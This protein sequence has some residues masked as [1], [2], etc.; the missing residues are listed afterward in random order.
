M[1]KSEAAAAQHPSPL[2]LPC[3]LP[4]ADS[5][6]PA[7]L[8]A[9]RQ[10]PIHDSTFVK[11]R[12]RFRESDD[13]RS[14][15]TLL[16]LYADHL[17]K[18]D[19]DPSRNAGKV[20][21][22]SHQAHELWLDRV[23]D[24]AEAA[25]ALARAVQA[26]PE[27]ERAVRHLYE[28]YSELGWHTERILLLRWRIR[29][30]ERTT[31]AAIP[32]L[33]VELAQI[34]DEH[35]MA[36]KEA[37][38]IYERALHSDPK[39]R[40]ASEGLIRLYLHASSWDRAAELMT[41]ELTRLD[42]G[43][44]RDRV[45]ELHLRLARI[46]HE[47]HDNIAGAAVHLQSA[48]KAMPDNVRALRAFGV[49]YLGSGKA[50]DEGMA[51]AAD[52]FFRAAK[53]AHAQNDE[54]EALKLLRRTLNLRPDHY[55]AG[56][57]LAEIFSDH[58]RWTDL[59][60]L[61]AQW[62]DYVAPEDAY[63]LWIQRGELLEEH[64]VRREDARLCYETAAQ[65]EA[66]GG[67]A[68]QYLERLYASLGD[69]E[70]LAGLFEVHVEREPASMPT[71]KLLRAAEIYREELHNDQRASFFFYMVLERE[72]FNAVAFEGYKEH[73]RRKNKWAHLRDLIFYQIEEA[74]NYS[75]PDNPLQSPSFA[76]EF[77]EVAE[78]CEKRL[79]DPDGALDAWQRLQS[80]YP[81]DRRPR[82]Q[83]ARLSKRIR[84]LDQI[85]R[86]QGLEL[87]RSSDQQTRLGLLRR[88]AAVYRERVVDPARAIDHLHESLTI[89]PEDSP[90]EEML[91]DLYS[92][93]GDSE[94]L[95]AILRQHYEAARRPAKQMLL[96]RRM[97]AIWHDDLQDHDNAI[98]ACEQL[99]SY[100][101]DDAEIIHRLQNLFY[102]TGRQEE[103]YTSLEREL[104]ITTEPRARSR[105]LL[106]MGNIAE[107]QLGD[108]RRASRVYN[109]LLALDPHNLEIIDK[110][111]GMY[112][113]D[114]RFDDL[115][116]LLGKA[117]ASSK[118]PPIRQLDY[119]TRLGHLA[120]GSL[121]DP[122]L[123]CSAFEKVLRIHHD[124][125]DAVEALTRLYRTI[126]AWHGLAAMLGNLQDLVDSDEEVL[127]LGLERAEVLTDNLD[128]A[129][130]AARVLE[131][132]DATI[133]PGHPE[134]RA[135]LTATYK[136]AGDHR[137]AIRHA[138]IL[139]LATPERAERQSLFE[140][141]ASSWIALNETKSGLAAFARFVE[142]VGYDPS[143]LRLQADLQEQAGDFAGALQTHDRLLREEPDPRRNVATLE[144]M[145]E[146]AEDKQGHH[147]R[148][149]AL[150]G[151]ALGIN[152]TDSRIR[153]K[154]EALAARHSMWKD[155]LAAYSERYNEMSHRADSRGQIEL[156]MNASRTAEEH[157]GDFD[158][159]FAWAKKA[160]L[161]ALEAGHEAQISRPPRDR[162]RELAQT[163][164]LWRQQL[165]VY[166]Q[167]LAL[168]RQD[169]SFGDFDSFELLLSAADVARERLHEPAR[170]IGFLTRAHRIRPEDGELGKQIEEI[171]ERHEL[172][173]ELGEHYEGLLTR[174]ESALSHFDAHVALARLLERKL[175]DAKGAATRLRTA[176]EQIYSDDRSLAEEALDLA[177]SLCERHE[178]WE[179]LAD[180]RQAAA[181]R[182]FDRRAIPEGLRSLCQAAT[183]LDERCGD[184]LAALRTLRGGLRYDLTGAG[185]L[186]PLRALAQRSDDARADGE[187]P[188][189]TLTILG[190]L[191][192]LIA[193]TDDPTAQIR[194][195]KE[196]A[197]IRERTLDDRRGALAEWLRILGLNPASEEARFE[198]DRLAE[199]G[200]LWD[201]M[202]LVPAWD[203]QQ[204]RRDRSPATPLT[205]RQQTQENTHWE[206]IAELY[207]DYLNRPEY[208]LRAKL[209]TWRLRRE[210][211]PTE[212]D[213]GPL[214]GSIWHHARTIG[215]YT[216]PPVH[217]DTL[218]WPQVRAPEIDDDALW[219]KLGLHP[220]TLRPR[221]GRAQAQTSTPTTT[222][223]DLSEIE[224]LDEPPEVTGILDFTELEPLDDDAIPEVTGILDLTEIEALDEPPP[225]ITGVVELSEI[226]PFDDDDDDD[227]TA[228][229]DLA[230]DDPGLLKFRAATA[231][232]PDAPITLDI[233]PDD[234]DLLAFR[235]G[236]LGSDAIAAKKSTRPP[237]P[238]GGPPRPPSR[239]HAAPPRPPS[240]PH[241]APLRA[242]PPRPPSRPIAAMTPAPPPSLPALTAGLPV[243]PSL[244]A[245]ILQAR[246]K[247]SGPWQEIEAAYREVT[248]PSKEDRARLALALARLY[249]EGA[250]LPEQSFALLEE[251]L[252]LL[253]EHTKA[254]AALDALALRR[255]DNERL[256]AA[257]SLL[258]SEVTLPEH[259]VEYSLRLA[260][261]QR[262]AGHDDAAETAYRGVLGV[263]P[264]HLGAL[265]ALAS[266]YDASGRD[267]EY[268]E[269]RG[270]LVDL[271]LPEAPT[272]EREALLRG[273]ARD[274]DQRL[275]RID[276]AIKRLEPLARELPARID[277]QEELADL[278]L[279]EEEWAA[280]ATVLR[281]ALAHTEGGC[282]EHLRLLSR[283]AL[284]EENKLD[285][286][287]AAI[288]RWQ[289]I[290]GTRAEDNEALAHLQGLYL[291][292]EHWQELIEII[293]R[294]LA[295]AGSARD[296]RIAI[297]VIKARA[298][299]EGF[300]DEAAA[301]S[302][303]EALAVEDPEND[304]VILGLSRLYRRS[305]RTDEGIAL[306]RRR[307]GEL[308]ADAHEE[309]ATLALA[310]ASIQSDEVGDLMEATAT[311]EEALGENPSHRELLRR[312]AS[313][314][315]QS[316]DLPVLVD[317]LERLGDA[318]DLLEAAP[319]ARNAL[320]D[321]EWSARLY[322]KVLASE[323]GA[324]DPK[325][326][327]RIA[328]ALS[329]LTE[330]RIAAGDRAGVD[331]LLAERIAALPTPLH[332][333]VLTE[334]GRTLWHSTADIDL[335][336]ARFSA[337]LAA[338]PDCALASHSLG[339]VLFLAGRYDEAEPILEEAVE[340][341]VLT[342]D[343]THLV[344]ALVLLA[345]L[346]EAT[347]RCAD[348]YRRLSS[349]LHQDP[350]SLEI[351][352]AI[353]R[354][355][356][357]VGRWQETLSAIAQLD[358]FLGTGVVLS[359][360]E[361]RQLAQ[362]Y[363][364]ASFAA[365]EVGDETREIVLF[366]Q[367][368]GHDPENI[369]IQDQ[370]IERCRERCLYDRQSRY[371]AAR[372]QHFAEPTK[373]GEALL[374]AGMLAADAA[375]EIEE[376]AENEGRDPSEDELF[377]V[378]DLRDRAFVSLRSGITLVG[379][380][381]TPLLTRRHL[382]V[383]FW[384][385]SSRDTATALKCL[386]RLV[387]RDDLRTESRLELLVE[388]VRLSLVRGHEGDD[389]S[390]QHYA[391]AACDA[392]P[393]RSTPISAM[394]D[395]LE[396]KGDHQE[397][398]ER[399]VLMFF[400]RQGLR[401][402][403]GETEDALRSA[404]LIRLAETQHEHPER[405]IRLLERAATLDARGLGVAER[406]H[407]TQLYIAA[408]TES[409]RIRQNYEA[410]LELDPTDTKN[411][412]ALLEICLHDGDIDQAA[413]LC[414]LLR[415]LD[416][417]DAKT[418]ALAGR[419]GVEVHD[420]ESFDINA[421]LPRKLPSG[422][423]IEA[424]HQ[425]GRGGAAILCAKLPR[426]DT[427]GALIP[428]ADNVFCRT[429]TDTRTRIGAPPYPVVDAAA[430]A[431]DIDDGWLL[432]HCQY[433]PV[434]VV[435]PKAKYEEAPG[436]LRF[437][438]GRSLF[439]ARPGN[440]LCE[441]LDREELAKVLAAV[442]LAFH[443]RHAQRR[444]LIQ[445]DDEAVLQLAQH[446][447]RKLPPKVSGAIATLLKEH[448]EESFDSRSWRSW[449]RR[450]GN[451]VGLCASGKIE[452]ALEF[453]G[454]PPEAKARAQAIRE[455]ANNN[456]EELRD[457]LGFSGSA[458]YAR[459]RRGLGYCALLDGAQAAPQQPVPDNSPPPSTDD[460]EVA[461]DPPST[462]DA[463]TPGA[464]DTDS[465]AFQS[466]DEA[467]FDLL[468][469][470]EDP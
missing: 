117:A 35:F 145:A 420:R 256:I 196:R 120:E 276:A 49:M 322:D 374:G 109:D 250:D 188:L 323:P 17:G 143:V 299:Q 5:N 28:L 344:E 439:F 259:I 258:V 235:A 320:D 389:D 215:T 202:L 253:P 74:T 467:E 160:Y 397:D 72:P 279:R 184:P 450:G 367:A 83:I 312:R 22:L 69:F 463:N 351:R 45:A 171:A 387:L 95:I 103:L 319:I 207:A 58:E 157:I 15:A 14:L 44:Q 307:L 176:W 29:R 55:D 54:R 165:D 163:H 57:M 347:D 231:R 85:A 465:I 280:A 317:T 66:P 334:L 24:P 297:L 119:L 52:I 435:G 430:V 139:L 169:S 428:G 254:Q 246:P 2:G 274:L 200:N 93:V 27:H 350:S 388:G 385:A 138:E 416:P 402:D 469:D 261:L 368:H 32:A 43:N 238:R 272:A 436:H 437:A 96:L 148:A 60:A 277:I 248:T 63:S 199:A 269:V 212:G 129:S 87:A 111:A 363:A 158:L 321:A 451:R 172:W 21:E 434:M 286:S 107:V 418:L 132:L 181:S 115:A 73:W 263:L 177:V 232:D 292:K 80:A 59:D 156:C 220:T 92:R 419:L 427:D 3:P 216:A 287:E 411:Q 105:I 453:L 333:R 298:L 381:S 30:S 295:L 125:R 40:A 10:G 20:A 462:N 36:I 357:H 149:M 71:D 134:I 304:A 314:A 12:R 401:S 241:S 94:G 329:G 178:L 130:A 364:L 278:L 431:F 124:H 391:Q 154:L 283:V 281:Q 452:I 167:E 141:I 398:I 366:E 204:M 197:E 122:D 326:I 415:V 456:D 271:Q 64:L 244:E 227:S 205:P 330:L 192:E 100:K 362:I 332:S 113:A 311:I 91:A 468:Q 372:A 46:E 128:N 224:T 168:Q 39:N 426:L 194:W 110:V 144:R 417:D 150:L 161:V 118:T 445:D 182:L 379:E 265:H 234:P 159:A 382:E 361:H 233:A 102:E 131:H 249:D 455:R 237:P 336:T 396:A 189:G 90:I 339:E 395:A 222:A 6:E 236:S 75:G 13:W 208:A 443:P 190:A 19:Q 219:R 127:R 121:M 225:E 449:V 461:D 18:S 123:A 335:A 338:D 380:E 342:R 282:D 376:S 108:K 221:P 11:L 164:D 166:E 260:E 228:T 112:E 284:L 201:L 243:I 50:S 315:R 403:Q 355:R 301:T 433:P 318:D 170:A 438:V 82:E 404:L 247:V 300:D 217:Q 421:V 384:V 257:Y 76:E 447:S 89:Q 9:F 229:V 392:F 84:M 424:M 162:L 413:A 267:R 356:Y 206:R 245:P 175:D 393:R 422:G 370:M 185:I 230:P 86:T 365:A 264:Q 316:E 223:V 195:L 470:P 441:A 106:R 268:V 410:I 31:P 432:P 8:T 378:R 400:N 446:L 275:H 239:P 442:L 53:L 198:L 187:P 114:G 67:Q 354:N 296:E 289:E 1:S 324:D 41:A 408:G 423:M 78:I 209:C 211:P 214:H 213:L 61:Y 425:L 337:A 65:Y 81:N 135:R 218:L 440:L 262:E 62:I 226:E 340:S 375:A 407:L 349:A 454:L 406:R 412:R 210:L 155:L 146:I 173:K 373:R 348:A 327:G 79:A 460:A 308:S 383:A 98:W 448:Q 429:W 133:A 345:R 25:H 399:L 174:G 444:E 56:I 37:I 26:A 353:I 147:R 179:E 180:I 99:L 242:A 390:A 186:G 16:V 23:K 152:P 77:A 358:E 306:L 341:H 302:T 88:L 7:E 371:T 405:A 309:R 42:P 346:F 252:I 116:N 240:Q 4:S 136:G 273:L 97:A 290:L 360:E 101:S 104:R 457:L 352:C 51:K 325:A 193:A 343:G 369:E 266:I 464:P 191:Q 34:L 294:R 285:E 291:G 331:A 251:A 183:L 33:L 293:D 48:L 458:L 409:S 459:A 414:G 466:Q 203:L 310:L 151:R 313:L 137:K 303:L 359:R 47:V 328:T 270:R 288:E 68:W 377:A 386:D 70:A 38:A 126:S 153:E 305:G 394:F 140:A 255:G 142:E